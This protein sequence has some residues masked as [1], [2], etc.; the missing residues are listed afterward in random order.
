MLRLYWDTG[1]EIFGK[2]LPMDPDLDLAM[3]LHRTGRLRILTAR[4]GGFLVGV[5][6]F[7]VG[8]TMYRK[9]TVTAIALILYPPNLALAVSPSL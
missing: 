1:G 2:E 9:S 4:R 8:S 5:N 6:S 7:N 3:F